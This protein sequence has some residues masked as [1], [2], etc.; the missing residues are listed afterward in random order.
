MQKYCFLDPTLG[1]LGVRVFISCSIIMSSIA[2]LLKQMCLLMSGK[3]QNLRPLMKQLP[4]P[5][6]RPLWVMLVNQLDLQ[7][8]Q[9]SVRSTLPM[10]QSVRSWGGSVFPLLLKLMAIGVKRLKTPSRDW[11]LF[12]QSANAFQKS[13]YFR[14]SYG[15]LNLSSEVSG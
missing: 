7:L 10:T 5:L 11:H 6:L 12:F 2:T 13:K 8:T 14:E 15:L 9:Q 3:G 4:L 1:H